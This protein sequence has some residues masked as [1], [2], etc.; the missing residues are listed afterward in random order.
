MC[1]LNNKADT[2]ITCG[3]QSNISICKLCCAAVHLIGTPCVIAPHSNDVVQIFPNFGLVTSLALYSA[4]QNGGKTENMQI[5]GGSKKVGAGLRSPVL[6][7]CCEN[8][9]S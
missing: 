2:V 9:R 7:S 1:L 8:D 6:H 5:Y 4:T 3:L